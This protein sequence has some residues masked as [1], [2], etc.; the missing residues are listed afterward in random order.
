M[1]PANDPV[2]ISGITEARMLTDPPL[3]D[4]TRVERM[5]TFMGKRIKYVMEVVDHDPKALLGMRSVKGP[6]SDEGHLRV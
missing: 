2:W 1:D 6:F 4:G 3:T 5:A